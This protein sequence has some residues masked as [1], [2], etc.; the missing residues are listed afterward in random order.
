MVRNLLTWFLCL[1]ILLAPGCTML[2]AED[3]N[4]ARAFIEREYDA[5]TITRA[6]RDAA[7][8]AIDNDE[9]FDWEM[10]GLFALNAV[11][12][13]VG[14]PFVVRKIRGSPLRSGSGAD[15]STVGAQP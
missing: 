13:L 12:A 5:G 14:G 1:C 11:M 9:P 6:Q 10:L 2:T 7:I 4:R 8:E 15:A 3:R